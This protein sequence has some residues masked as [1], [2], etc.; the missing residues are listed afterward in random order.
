[1]NKIIVIEDDITLLEN[2]LEFLREEGFDTYS[3]Q[4]GSL[5]LLMIKEVNPDLILCDIGLPKMNGLDTCTA[6]KK[7]DS[8]KDIPVIF[9][10][11]YGDDDN[12]VKGFEAGAQDYIVKPFRYQELLAR[13]NTHI[14]LK[15]KKDQ[16]QQVNNWLEKKVKERTAELENAYRQLKSANAALMK[17]D[18]IKT[19]FLNIISHELRTPLNGIIGPLQLLKLSVDNKNLA[20]VIRLID[21]SA[22]RLEEFSLTAL[23]ITLFKSGKNKFHIVAEPAGNL[24]EFAILK[25]QNILSEKN[26]TITHSKESDLYIHGD[27]EQ[28]IKSVAYILEALCTHSA[29]ATKM[30]IHQKQDSGNVRFDI[31]NT[32]HQINTESVSTLFD[33]F[34]YDYHKSDHNLGLRLYLAK[35]IIEAHGGHIEMAANKKSG[36]TLS[37]FLPVVFTEEVQ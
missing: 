23:E 15:H 28:I 18:E 14:D 31:I 35:Q 29:P 30:N 10:T 26:I 22:S 24:I 16:L 27:K 12:I 6:I 36:I 2:T 8:L 33:L 7:T 11:A 1:M 5:G 20:E 13:V 21:K 32:C 17:L 3:A 34:R 37:V 25:T 9:L 19:E 4:D